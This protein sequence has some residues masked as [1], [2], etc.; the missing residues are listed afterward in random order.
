MTTSWKLILKKASLCPSFITILSSSMPR[1]LELK[2]DSWNSD[3][4]LESKNSN[5]QFFAI[6]AVFLII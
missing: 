5:V 2:Y 6:P 4:L 3:C 1:Y